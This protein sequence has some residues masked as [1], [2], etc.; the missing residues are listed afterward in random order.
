MCKLV[1]KILFCVSVVFIWGIVSVNSVLA[2]TYYM[3][4]DGS[5]DCANL[6]ECI[7]IMNGGDELII[8]DGVYAGDENM[9]SRWSPPP[10]GTAEHFTTIKA[11]HDGMVIFPDGFLSWNGDPASPVEYVSFEGLKSLQETIIRGMH[12]VKFLRCAFT[13]NA[14][15]EQSAAAPFWIGGTCT[16]ILVEDCWAWGAGRYNFVAGGN[17]HVFRRC[18]ARFDRTDWTDPMANFSS[19]DADYVTYQNCIAIDSNHEEFWLYRGEISGNFYI[20]H[21]SA[22]NTV[23]G[24]IGVNNHNSWINGAPGPGL[25]I[26]NNVAV[27]V[28][29]YAYLVRGDNYSPGSYTVEN[30]TIIDVDGYGINPWGGGVQTVSAINNV[31]YS[32]RDIALNGTD[33]GGPGSGYNVLYNNITDYYGNSPVVTDYCMDNGNSVDPIDGIPGNGVPSILYPIRIESGSDLSGTGFDGRD[34]GANILFKIGV[35]GT[36]YGDPGWDTVTTESLWPWSNEDRIQEDMRSYSYTGITTDGTIKTLIG[37]R[38]FAEN[39]NDQFGK[40]L[41]LTR[42]IWQYLGNEI[43]CEIYDECTSTA[44]QADVDQS[45]TIN[46]TDAMLTLRNSLGMNMSSTNWQTSDTTGDVNC[47]DS[48]NI[49]DVLL[50][51][52]YSLGLSMSGTGWCEN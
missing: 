25:K 24:C 21:G 19:Y 30:C 48:V 23:N 47:D 5:E 38:G 2:A 36:F 50:I 3:N 52:R 17:H 14:Y 16:Y 41:T 20:H 42:Y 40:P 1:K 31:L 37:N 9:I 13:Y 15:P 7:G 51:L 27:D 43:P 45:G 12:H 33:L 35:S 18:V 10:N 29:T 34:R 8:R 22:Y 46:S 32:V 4:A 28:G 49:T 44:I 6:Q 39:K 11:E 26:I